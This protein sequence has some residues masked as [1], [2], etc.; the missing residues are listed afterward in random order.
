MGFSRVV[1]FFQEHPVADFAAG[2]RGIVCVL[3]K[4]K[5]LPVIT[6]EHWNHRSLLRQQVLDKEKE[7][8]K[9]EYNLNLINEVCI[10][11]F[12]CHS[13]KFRNQNED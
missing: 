12:L 10:S 11:F 3:G 7:L 2:G 5:P 9:N 13:N 6:D 8:V 4:P 1:S